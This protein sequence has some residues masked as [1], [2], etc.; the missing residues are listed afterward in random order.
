MGNAESTAIPEEKAFPGHLYRENPK[1]AAG[2][3]HR[4]AGTGL[5]SPQAALYLSSAIGYL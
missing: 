1:T 2:L 5:P 3:L 4:T